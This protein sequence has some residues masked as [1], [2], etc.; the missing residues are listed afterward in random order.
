MFFS[1]QSAT[2]PRIEAF[3]SSL[4]YA[5]RL[6]ELAENELA[7]WKSTGKGICQ[8]AAIFNGAKEKH[9]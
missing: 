5:V 7:F 9:H 1:I 2:Y 3:R 6:W 8:Q 4:D